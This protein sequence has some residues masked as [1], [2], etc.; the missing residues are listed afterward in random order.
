[1]KNRLHVDWVPTERT[2]DAEVERVLALGARL[3]E[4]HRTVEGPGWVT[5]LDLEGNEF[6]IDAAPPS[7]ASDPSLLCS[8]R[9]KPER[10]DR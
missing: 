3:H 2:R 10:M 7:A 8:G 4:D 9:R 1:M 5:L 6:C